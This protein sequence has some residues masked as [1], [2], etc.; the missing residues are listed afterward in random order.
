MNNC[1]FLSFGFAVLYFRKHA[2]H[3]GGHGG[4]ARLCPD[5]CG[6][7]GQA[8]CVLLQEHNRDGGWTYAAVCDVPL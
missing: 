2:L 1:P 4:H 7:G 3:A 8:T 5:V 6:H